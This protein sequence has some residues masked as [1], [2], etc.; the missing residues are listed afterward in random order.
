[1]KGFNTKNNSNFFRG[2]K[3]PIKKKGSTQ[4]DGSN[5]NN[6]VPPVIVDHKMTKK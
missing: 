1:M 6:T 2:S 4:R 5:K 3:K